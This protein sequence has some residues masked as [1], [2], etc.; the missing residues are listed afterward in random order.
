M[1]IEQIDILSN[2]ASEFSSFAKLYQEE[3][4]E[5]DLVEILS[6]QEILFNNRD[7]IEMNFRSQVGKAVVLARKEQITRTFVNLITNAIQAVENKEHGI[8]NIT[9]GGCGRQRRRCLKG[10]YGKTVP[11]Q[12]HHKDQRL[13][14]RTGYLQ[15]HHN[16]EPRRDKLLSVCLSWRCRLLCPTSRPHRR[17]R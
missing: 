3:Q 2:T 12:L 9:P 11:S 5:I 1:L 16:T 14:T 7:N 10:E 17:R 13:G 4:T 6:E 8:I 15:K